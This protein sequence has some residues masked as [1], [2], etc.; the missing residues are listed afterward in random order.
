[1]LLN[2][3]RYVVGPGG[4]AGVCIAQVKWA[5][6]ILP[7]TLISGVYQAVSHKLQVVHIT[8]PDAWVVHTY[9]ACSP[10]ILRREFRGSPNKVLVKPGEGMSLLKDRLSTVE[11]VRSL[12]QDDLKTLVRMLKCEGGGRTRATLLEALA[13]HATA[14]ETPDSVD[15]FVK[16]VLSFERQP[17]KAA[18]VDVLTE[19]VFGEMEQDDQKEFEFTGKAISAMNQKRKFARWHAEHGAPPLPLKK[20]RKLGM[21]NFRGKG[22][23]KGKKAGAPQPGDSTDGKGKGKGEGKDNGKGKDAM[24]KGEGMED[25]AAE[26]GEASSPSTCEKSK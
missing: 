4:I 14:G 6:L 7:T 13:K 3:Q 10:L 23:G 11:S 20:K 12:T 17:P 21:G 16:L 18:D 26:G 2:T 8:D 1:M 15:L 9:T 25:V 5:A 24:G 19:Q 22:K